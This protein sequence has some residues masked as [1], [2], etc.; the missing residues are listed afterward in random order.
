M[1]IYSIHG[2]DVRTKY[3]NIVC[4]IMSCIIIHIP[5]YFWDGASRVHILRLLWPI[6][7]TTSFYSG[8]TVCSC[9]IHAQTYTHLAASPPPPTRTYTC[10]SWPPQHH[11]FSCTTEMELIW[12]IS[13]LMT[14]YDFTRGLILVSLCALV[15]YTRTHANLENF[16][17]EIFS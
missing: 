1:H 6:L 2:D 11:V 7:N 15:L 3:V 9:I 8:I 4:Y 5:M 13:N 17:V 12:C 14:K 10:Y 16:V